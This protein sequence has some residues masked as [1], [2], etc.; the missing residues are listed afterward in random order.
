MSVEVRRETIPPWVDLPDGNQ[1]SAQTLNDQAGGPTEQTLQVAAPNQVIPIVY[2][3]HLVGP[4][5]HALGTL[6]LTPL[7]LLLGATWSQGPVDAVEQI[8]LDGQTPTEFLS[9]FRSV[10][11]PD[12]STPPTDAM[13]VDGEVE[14]FPGTDSQG[15]SHTF[16]LGDGAGNS[17]LFSWGNYTDANPGICW[18]AF[19]FDNRDFEA[20]G[21][22]TAIPRLQALVR[23][24]KVYDPRD[25]AQV[26]GDSSTYT[27]SPNAALILADFIDRFSG[28]GVNWDSVVDAADWA[29]ED[30]TTGNQATAQQL[31]DYDPAVRRLIGFRL[32]KPVRVDKFIETLAQYAGCFAVVDGSNYTLI[33]DMPG[34]AQRTITTGD[35]VRDSFRVKRPGLQN[36]PTIVEVSYSKPNDEGDPWERK[37]ED[38]G[39]PPSGIT[40]RSTINMPFF[41]NAATAGR[42]AVERLN[43]FLLAR[44]DLQWRTFDEGIQHVRGDLLHVEHPYL[45]GAMEVRVTDV[46]AVDIGLWEVRATEHDNAIYSDEVRPEPAYWAGTDVFNDSA[47]SVTFTDDTWVDTQAGQEA[48]NHRSWLLS[49]TNNYPEDA[50]FRSQFLQSDYDGEVRFEKVTSNEP[51]DPLKVVGPS[52]DEM[53]KPPNALTQWCLRVRVERGNMVGPWNEDAG[54]FCVWGSGPQDVPPNLVPSFGVQQDAD[55]LHFRW[56]TPAP[57]DEL[58]YEIRAIAEADATGSNGAWDD[59]HT[60]VKTGIDGNSLSY[61]ASRLP[62]PGNYFFKIKASHKTTGVDSN[63]AQTTDL[64]AVSTNNFP[65]GR[66]ADVASDTPDGGQARLWDDGAGEWQSKWV[67]EDGSGTLPQVKTIKVVDSLPGTPDANTLYFVKE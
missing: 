13:A 48:V 63:N 49:G 7:Y 1:A 38:T 4:R 39:A 51:G 50:V 29:G 17:N 18:S 61:Q 11:R 43:R 23:G 30:V 26:Q 16:T 35:M 32:D 37:T 52:S 2:G 25:G 56:G 44:T 10:S 58:E 21:P 57:Y 62:G 19:Q 22:G 28:R 60:V 41:L 42:F 59:T 54:A 3:R 66:L 5:F 45:P 47:P 53:G 64:F 36:S 6:Q 34:A 24:V 12:T 31:Q 67:V 14:T 9:H 65:S 15:I 20:G 55:E 8:Y 46:Q 27:W 33:P 40:R